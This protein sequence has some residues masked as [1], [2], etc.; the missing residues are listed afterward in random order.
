MSAMENVVKAAK[1]AAATA[2]SGAKKTARIAKSSSK[3][4]KAAYD[5]ARSSVMP[6]FEEGVLPSLGKGIKAGAS[7]AARKF[8]GLGSSGKAD[9]AGV[10][11]IP[12]LAAL[13][14]MSGGD[15]GDMAEMA[16]ASGIPMGGGDED[17]VQS[18]RA[19]M[20]PKV[21]RRIMNEI[22]SG[23]RPEKVLERIQNNV[24]SQLADA[25]SQIAQETEGQYKADDLYKFSSALEQVL[26]SQDTPTKK[27]AQL[28]A[29]SGD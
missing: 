23:K 14:L 24:Y 1:F 20:I 18:M 15:E 26:A 13:S 19:A 17:P 10:T 7:E 11:G 5:L 9:V 25:N 4:G 22:E 16:D 6:G 21:K 3:A 2:R 29:L 27:L 8:G 12:L 28:Y